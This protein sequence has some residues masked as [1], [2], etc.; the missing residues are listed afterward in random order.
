MSFHTHNDDHGN[1]NA[2]APPDTLSTEK[3]QDATRKGAEVV[4]R[5]DNALQTAAWVVECGQPVLVV[6]DAGEDALVISEQHC[7]MSEVSALLTPSRHLPKA[8]WQV[9]MMAN[10]VGRPGLKSPMR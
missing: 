4:D 5:D 2:P 7:I 9:T 10:C 3:R 6:D 1:E 8:I